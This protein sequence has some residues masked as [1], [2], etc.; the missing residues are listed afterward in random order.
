MTTKAHRET[1]RGL[2]RLYRKNIMMSLRGKIDIQIETDRRRLI[3]FLYAYKECKNLISPVIGS[4][5]NKS[6]VNF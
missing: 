4:S 1:G 6:L 3:D 2:D 5:N